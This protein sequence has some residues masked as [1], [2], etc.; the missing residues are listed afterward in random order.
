[1]ASMCKAPACRW[2][3]GRER[4]SVVEVSVIVPACNVEATLDGCLRSIEG[5]TLSAFEAIVLNDGSTDA[6]SAIA[7]GHAARDPRVSVVDKPNEGYGA[8][9]NR[10]IRL[11]QGAWVA[12]VEP[13]D[14]V[15]PDFLASMVACAAELGGPAAV[16]VV[17][18]PY[19]RLFDADGT[20]VKCPYA[21]RVKP[22]TQPFAVGAGAELLRHHPAIWAALYSR[23]Y[24]ERAGIR[25]VEA[26]GA[27]WVDNPF[28]V[29]TLCR[30]DRIA[31]TE[32]CGYVYRERDLDEAEAA[33]AKSPLLP[34]TR[35]NDMMD[36]AEAA[37]APAADPCVQA[38][39]ALRGVNYA[40]ITVEAAG[41]GV[42]GVPELLAASFARL[43]PAVVW[44]E[45]AI[46]PAGRALFAEVRGLEEPRGGRA[47]RLAYLARE[48][49][50]RVRANGVGFALRTARRRAAEGRLG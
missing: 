34:L 42:P 22:S 25:F 35:W 27:G 38:A 45:P 19:W 16:D 21:G 30:T 48:V 29:E 33:A 46:S 13:D 31:Y 23:A 18:A 37:G 9:C 40:L 32:A 10:G 44:A 26:P 4:V 1:M 2:A 15:E 50:Y 12:I 14:Y 5:Q 8:T 49:L 41:R 39:L 17:K 6:T 3:Q 36:A 47:R 7:H 24:L 28:L 20:R 11:A 43:D